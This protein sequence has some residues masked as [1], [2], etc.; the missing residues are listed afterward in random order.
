MLGRALLP[1][2]AFQRSAKSSL[3]KRSRS[4]SKCSAGASA[5]ASALND[6]GNVAIGSDRLAD[7]EAYFR[8][9]GESIGLCTAT[10]TI[11]SALRRR[12]SRASTWPGRTTR[13]RNECIAT[14]YAIFSRAQSP[15]HLN[16]GIARIKLGRSLPQA[17]AAGQRRSA[18]SKAGYD[19]VAKQAAPTRELAEDRT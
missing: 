11:W 13:P 14:R 5:V 3:T 1:G 9:I 12:T 8:R 4:R 16:T 17:A 2:R 15:G 6:L 18:K 10:S 19:I 7:A